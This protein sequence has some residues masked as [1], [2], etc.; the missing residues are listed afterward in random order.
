MVKLIRLTPIGLTF[1]L[2]HNTFDEEDDVRLANEWNDILGPIASEHNHRNDMMTRAMSSCQSERETSSITTSTMTNTTNNISTMTPL[3]LISSIAPIVSTTT[4]TTS[5]SS[6]SRVSTPILDT[7]S[8]SS[9]MN[10]SSP[11]SIQSPTPSITTT[12]TPHI[13]NNTESSSCS[14]CNWKQ[15]THYGYDGTQGQ[16]YMV[17]VYKSKVQHCNE[18]MTFHKSLQVNNFVQPDIAYLMA[19]Y[20]DHYAGAIDYPDPELYAVVHKKVDND[21]FKY[22]KSLVQPYWDTFYAAALK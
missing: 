17:E 6:S 3:T 16:G 1:L 21:T 20:S 19:C 7:A 18:L 14:G 13:I 15:P 9:P 4:T 8:R 22:N 11:I 12:F 2:D 5:S 10:T